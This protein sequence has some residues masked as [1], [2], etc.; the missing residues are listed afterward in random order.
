MLALGSTPAL[1]QDMRYRDEIVITGERAGQGLGAPA[2]VATGLDLSILDMPASV[3]TVDLLAQTRQGPRTVAEATRGVTGLTFTTRAGAPGVFQSRG[4]TENALATLY[5]GLRVQSATISAR[6]YDPFNFERIEVVRGPSSLTIGEGAAAG[7]VNY[8]RRKPRLGPLSL[9]AVADVGEQDRLRFGAAVAG[10]LSDTIGAVLSA[11]WQRLG[12]FVDD[13][14]SRTLHVVSGLGGRVG[15]R[16]GFLLEADHLRARVDDAYWGTPLVN[17]TVDPSIRRRNYNLSPDNRMADD[18]TWLRG[19]FTYELSDALDYRGQV[20]HYAADRDWR[21]FY[22]FAFVPGPPAQVEVRS[23]DNLAYD[24]RLTGTRHDLKLRTDLGR[25]SSTTVFAFDYSDTDFASPRRDGAPS[26]GSPRPRFDLDDPAPAPFVQ[27]PRLLQ[28]EADVRQA[29]LSIEQ[30]LDFGLIELIGGARVTWIDATIAR[31]EASPPVPAFDVD[32]APVDFRAAVLLKPAENH[33]LYATVTSGAE[34]VESLLLLPLD[35]ANFRL[36]GTTG[37]ELGYKAVLGPVELTAAIYHIEKTRLP[38]IDPND[39]N[40]PPQIG[41]QRSRGF[42]LGAAWRQGPL[43]LSANLAYTDAEFRQFNDFGAFR[44]AVRPA[45]VP[46]WVANAAIAW[47][48]AEPVTLGGFVQHVGSRP[49][50]NANILFLPAYT[51]LDL[52]A[53]ARITRQLTLTLRMLNVTDETYVEW[54]TQSFGQNNLYFGSPRRV[55][56]SVRV[57]F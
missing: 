21:N 15:A 13:V 49:S 12:S 20:Y 36:T 22:A 48:V 45:N 40:L 3:D 56:G 41:E 42:E 18:V 46:E 6:A 55:E 50:N 35:Q 17:G 1:A 24:H 44:D 32:F 43:S 30:R 2:S 57:Q 16:G 53:E 27:G 38:S 7:A 39:P 31:P 29:G 33:S 37:F 28:R 34:P 25:I 11:S 14:D 54:A 26:D 23:V 47:Q 52:F 19:V 51:T 8:V 4:F 9:D 10:G 5:D